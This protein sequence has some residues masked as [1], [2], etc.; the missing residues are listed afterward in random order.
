[1]KNFFVVLSMLFIASCGSKEEVS[2]VGEAIKVAGYQYKKMAEKAPKGAYPRSVEPNDSIRW[3]NARDWTSGFFPGSLFY[4]YE[5]TEDSSFRSLG[6]KFTR[7]LHVLEY[8]SSTHDLGFM[9]YCSYG[10]AFRISEDE[11]YAKLMLNGANSLS[12]R[13]DETTGCIRSWDFGPWQFP[14]IIDNMMNLEYLFWAAKHSGDKRYYNLAV[15]HANTTLENHFREDFSSF[16]VVDYDTVTGE[17]LSRETFQ[18]YS[19]SSS[20]SRGQGWALYGYTMSYRETGDEEY[21]DHAE[22]I[23]GFILNHP[24]LPQDKVPYWDFDAPDI[25][26]A[27]RDASA[28][29]VIASAL[30]ELSGY[31]ENGEP[32]FLAAEQMLKSL[33]SPEYLAER[34]SNNFFILKHSTGFKPNNSEIDVPLNYADYYYLEGL[35]R[36]LELQNNSALAAE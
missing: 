15:D 32:Y 9:I 19:D 25:P 4:L 11:E 31:V 33:S 20:W 3:V 13:Y 12:S 8:D 22:R 29:A 23:A 21:L 6:E 28:A 30:L 36:Y 2:W 14:V 24:N 26:D 34:G 16:H 5:L 18:G 7:P 10:N 17:V 27:P 35:K 1:M